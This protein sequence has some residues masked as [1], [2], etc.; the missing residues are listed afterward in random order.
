M[1]FN[2]GVNVVKMLYK[3]CI[4]INPVYYDINVLQ[5]FLKNGIML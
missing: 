3:C 4:N 2:T 5:K 1:F